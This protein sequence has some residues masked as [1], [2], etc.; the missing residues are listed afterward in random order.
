M[1]EPFGA[2][3]NREVFFR[4]ST[5]EGARHALRLKVKEDGIPDQCGVVSE[6][7]AQNDEA[8]SSKEDYDELY[9]REDFDN[10]C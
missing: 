6:E 8:P 5:Q 4:A 1:A 2:T 9:T 7:Q 10:G 3:Y